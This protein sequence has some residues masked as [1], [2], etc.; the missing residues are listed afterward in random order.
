MFLSYRQEEKFHMNILLR[1]PI[2][3][4]CPTISSF[5]H[6]V[7]NTDICSL[8]V[9][10]SSSDEDKIVSYNFEHCA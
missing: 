2:V 4:V 6:L 8:P 9:F 3:N 10:S 1:H 7:L 5:Y